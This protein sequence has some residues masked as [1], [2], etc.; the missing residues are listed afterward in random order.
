MKQ[1]KPGGL[2]S[3]SVGFAWLRKRM[4]SEPEERWKGTTSARLVEAS[5]GSACHRHQLSAPRLG[6]DRGGKC[7]CQQTGV[8]LAADIAA[9]RIFKVNHCGFD[10]LV[11]KPGG[12][13]S[14]IDVALQMHAGKGGPVFV[15]L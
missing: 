8:D 7:G 5:P 15:Q 6:V 9:A 11:A 13:G 2:G 10:V 4:R 3:L 1:K 14:N 12:D